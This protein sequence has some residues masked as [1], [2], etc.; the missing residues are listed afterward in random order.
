MLN[1]VLESAELLDNLLALGLLL[2]V[3][4]LGDGAIDVVNGTSLL[5]LAT[6]ARILREKSLVSY[7]NNGPSL[8]DRVACKGR[9]VAGD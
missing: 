1:L 4:R 2:G 3:V 6:D 8:A 5:Q 7:Q 9:G